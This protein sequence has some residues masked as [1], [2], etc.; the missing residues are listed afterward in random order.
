[1]F[2]AV[3]FHILTNVH[4]NSSK[5]HTDGC[6]VLTEDKDWRVFLS[7]FLVGIL[8]LSRM[9]KIVHFGSP[10][11]GNIVLSLA[12]SSD[13]LL[14]THI[15]TWTVRIDSDVLEIFVQG[16][17]IQVQDLVGVIEDSQVSLIMMFFFTSFSNGFWFLSLRDWRVILDMVKD[18]LKITLWENVTETMDMLLR[19]LIIV[20]VMKRLGLRFGTH[21]LGGSSVLFLFIFSN[22]LISMLVFGSFSLRSRNF[23]AEL[24]LLLRSLMSM[25]PRAHLVMMIH[26]ATG[27]VL[28]KRMWEL[29]IHFTMVRWRLLI[30]VAVIILTESLVALILGLD[31]TLVVKLGIDDL[32]LLINLTVGTQLDKRSILDVVLVKRT[33]RGY[34]VSSSKN[35]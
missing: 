1:M 15:L 8:D 25:V 33:Y 5:L 13:S 35:C 7:V 14:F 26:L 22:S 24:S 29:L 3:H 17:W 9:A 31:I 6:F 4:T 34:V 28:R 20:V 19:I 18:C 32:E 2:W 16:L 11:S 10:V 23:F 12:S 27:A 30:H 21:D